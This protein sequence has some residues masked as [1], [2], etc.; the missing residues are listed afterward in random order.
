MNE[1]KDRTEAIHLDLIAL[2]S[3]A[4]TIHLARRSLGNAS[5][6]IECSEP[7]MRR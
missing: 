6:A 1:A 7:K 4:F 2:R 3:A 5:T